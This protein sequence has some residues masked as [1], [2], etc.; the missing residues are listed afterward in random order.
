MVVEFDLRKIALK[1]NLDTT[2]HDGDS[3]FIPR[4]TNNIHILGE[5]RNPSTISYVENMTISDAINFGGNYTEFADTN[6]IV[7][8]DPDGSIN[9]INYNG[10]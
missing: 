5:I 1:K 6:N 3:I 4:K 9:F 2:L 10:V 7:V 8:V